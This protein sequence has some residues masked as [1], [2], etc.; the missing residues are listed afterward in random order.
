MR[1]HNAE[2][3]RI[4][5]AY[6]IYLKEARRLGEHS[7]DA[8]ASAIGRF[9]E[10]TK[11][12]DFKRFHT[13]QAVGFKRRFSGEINQRTGECRSKSTVF[14][15]LNAL[16]AFFQWLAGQSGYRSFLTY[17][18]SDYFNLSEK[19]ARVA[20]ASPEKRTPSIEQILHVLHTMPGSSPIGKRNRAVV[21]FIL[22]TGVR[23]GAAASL[24]LRHIDLAEGK[25]LQDAREVRTKFSKTFT[26]WFFPV[27]D[28][29]RQIIIDWV[30]FLR[31]D[32]VFGPDDPLFP[33]TA[34]TLGNDQQFEATGLSRSHWSTATPIRR[35]FKDA[36]TKAG[37]PYFNPHSIRR[38]LAQLG[39]RLCHT[40]EEFKAWSQNL[41]HEMALTTFSSYGEVARDRQAKL[42][43]QLGQLSS[44][45]S[46]PKQAL[47]QLLHYV[48]AQ[49][50][51]PDAATND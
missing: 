48:Q 20:K 38:T 28:E 41:G 13:Q 46:Y 42:I 16:R 25:V 44:V 27:G 12:R 19:E 9:E 14:T 32:M 3:E 22:L 34:V 2:N 36:F 18:D 7:I 37:L 51:R 4:K 10:Y 35:T 26:T 47:E 23:D 21:A 33:A 50:G 1:K 15:T 45:P 6:F 24:K 17:S 40:P 30:A 31:T 11:Y 39:E 5:R 49:H 8:A 29:V 43:R